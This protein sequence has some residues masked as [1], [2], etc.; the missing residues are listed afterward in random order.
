MV[1]MDADKG[2]VL[3]TVDIG[4]G[5]DGCGVDADKGLAYGS[6]GGDGTLTVIG[7]SEPGKFKAIAN[8][9][10]QAIARTMTVDPKTHRVYLS[11]AA[12]LPAPADGQP[13]TKGFRRGTVPGSFVIV[14]VGD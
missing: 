4:R 11:A 1:V 9:P 8:V 14:V 7:E 6:N 3:A 10:T 12:P 2:T 5:S 13:K